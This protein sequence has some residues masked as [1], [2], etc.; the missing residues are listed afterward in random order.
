[1][2]LVWCGTHVLL[3][4]CEGAA[5]VWCTTQTCIEHQICSF[6]LA[7]NINT[8][9]VTCIVGIVPLAQPHAELLG[10][11]LAQR[12]LA[13]A[14]WAV[15]Q[16]DLVPRHQIGI[17]A[18]LRESEGGGGMTQQPLL[19]ICVIDQRVPQTME[20]PA[21]VGTRIDISATCARCVA[22]P[23]AG[24]ASCCVTFPLA[25]EL[26]TLQLRRRIYERVKHITCHMPHCTKEIRARWQQR[27]TFYSPVGQLP[28]HK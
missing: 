23:T 5:S 17:Y 9:K 21:C 28:L 7:T 8:H 16:H 12:R 15:Q 25:A 1:M 10:Q 13:S 22:L 14:R 20:A 2:A 27:Q 26:A 11:R 19:H 18:G 24:A 3:N 4:A 6:C